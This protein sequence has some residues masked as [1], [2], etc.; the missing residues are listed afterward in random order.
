MHLGGF[1]FWREP[2]LPAV[3]HESFALLHHWLTI[4]PPDLMKPASEPIMTPMGT[5]CA[6]KQADF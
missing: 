2:H 6:P 5:E 1:M 4:K 3:L